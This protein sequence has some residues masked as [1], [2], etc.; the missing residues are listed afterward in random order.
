MIPLRW[1]KRLAWVIIA[2]GLFLAVLAVLAG[3]Y[4]AWQVGS[5]IG[6]WLALQ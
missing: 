5:A 6:D 1:R 2:V 4:F 3:G